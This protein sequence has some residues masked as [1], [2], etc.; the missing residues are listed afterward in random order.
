METVGDLLEVARGRDGVAF[1]APSRTTGYSFREFVTSTWK[2]ANLLRQYGVHGGAVVAVAVGPKAPG[3]DDEPGRLGAAPD[4][5]YAALGAMLLGAVVDLDPTPTVDAAALVAPAAWIDRYAA[6]PGTAR[7]AYG[8][9]P[10]AA[11]VVHF[12]RERWSE[13]PVAPP[14]R[15]DAEARALL[16]SDAPT[17]GGLVEGARRAVRDVPLEGGD[18]VGLDGRL[19]PDALAA[20][21]LA[22]LAAGATI[23]GG[24]PT[25]VDVVVGP[26]GA[27]RLSG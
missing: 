14:N 18:L 4:P 3:S 17:H 9:P 22:P 19:G 10:E 24:D 11:D 27:R 26:D 23:V 25:D 1:D 15:V 16:G 21:I 12:E 13:N 6:S 20:G 5:L 7:L 2:A 8:G